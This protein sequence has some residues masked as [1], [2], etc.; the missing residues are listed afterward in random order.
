[1]REPTDQQAGALINRILFGG[2]KLHKVLRHGMTMDMAMDAI[3][4]NRFE[5]ENLWDDGEP[6]SLHDYDFR[7]LT[8]YREGYEEGFGHGWDTSYPEVP[9]VEEPPVP[10]LGEPYDHYAD[11]RLTA[12][13]LGFYDAQRSCEILA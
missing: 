4:D 2:P 5:E 13:V 1:M 9:D 11:T 10:K 6:D 8:T 7:T 12:Y 3:L